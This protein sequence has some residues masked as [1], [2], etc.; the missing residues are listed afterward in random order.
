MARPRSGT[1]ELRE[2]GLVQEAGEADARWRWFLGQE[3]GG[4]EGSHGRALVGWIEGSHGRALVGWIE[5]RMG[6]WDWMTGVSCAWIGRT[7]GWGD[8][9]A[10]KNQEGGDWLRGDW[11]ED[12]IKEGDSC[13]WLAGSDLAGEIPR[14]I[15]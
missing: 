11:V 14:G 2:A 8:W 9:A 3:E 1:K 6:R 4:I 13:G 7:D 12:E 15:C 10:L 5:G